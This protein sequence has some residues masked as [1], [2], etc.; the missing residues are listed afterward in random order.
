[1]LSGKMTKFNRT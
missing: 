1:M